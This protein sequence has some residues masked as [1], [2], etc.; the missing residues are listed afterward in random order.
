MPGSLQDVLLALAH[1]H[2]RFILAPEPL[3]I[4]RIMP[5]ETVHSPALA[6]FFYE[7]G[8]GRAQTRVAEMMRRFMAEGGLCVA[9]PLLL[10]SQFHQLCQGGLFERRFWNLTDQVAEAEIDQAAEFAVETFLRAHG[11]PAPA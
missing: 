6:C 1:R 3:A 2:L 9:D 5:A 8:P 7:Q 11:G 10:A 4:L